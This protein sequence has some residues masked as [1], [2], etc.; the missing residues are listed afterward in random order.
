M[1]RLGPIL[2]AAGLFAV[3]AQIALGHLP[4]ILLGPAVAIAAWGVLLAVW[5][6]I[7]GAGARR[8]A[9]AACIAL[10][11]SLANLRPTNN[12]DT[13]SIREQPWAS[14]LQTPAFA[15][16]IMLGEASEIITTGQKVLPKKAL[17]AG[18]AFKFTDVEAA[19]K[20]LL[21]T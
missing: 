6:S 16:R 9:I 18:Y 3:A 20:D 10:T 4:P 19:L 15:L 8:A 12:G 11:A 5:R 17:A 13:E 2:A 21:A 7:E 1:H 14:F